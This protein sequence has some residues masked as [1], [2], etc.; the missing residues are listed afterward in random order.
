MRKR[1]TVLTAAWAW[2]AAA[3]I[4]LSGGCTGDIYSLGEQGSQGSGGEAGS[5]TSN[6][7]T[8]TGGPA[9]V[10]GA[11]FACSTTAQPSSQ[12]WRRLSKAEYQNTMRDLLTFGL[13]DATAVSKVM[14]AL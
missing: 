7:G 11:A 6:G 1:T 8:S 12:P 5:Q 9:S 10:S 14:A 4:T 2:G 3:S 13:K